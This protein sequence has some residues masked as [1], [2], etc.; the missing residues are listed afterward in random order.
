MAEEEKLGDTIVAQIAKTVKFSTDKAI[1]DRVNRVGQKIAAIANTVQVPAGFGNDHVYPFKWTFN[2]IE[3]PDIN[4]FSIEGGHIYIYTGLMRLIGSDDELAGILGHEITHAAHHHMDA[5]AHEASKMD[6]K[7]AIAMIAAAFAHANTNDLGNV[8]MGAD[9]AE[10]AVLKN[11]YGEDAERDADYCG[12]IYMQKAGYDPVGMLTIQE[13]LLDVERQS[14]VVIEGTIF[15]DHPG[16]EERVQAVKD[17]LAALHITPTDEEIAR[18]S[19][20]ATQFIA[21][22]DASGAGMRDISFN[23]QVCATLH[24]PDGT[25]SA[26]L[27]ATLN[28]EMDD[29]LKFSEVVASGDS[30]LLRDIPW[31]TVLP[32]DASGQPTATVAQNIAHSLQVILYGRTFVPIDS[33]PRATISAGPD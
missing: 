13:K 33:T 9:L 5:E 3:D 14:P 4:A 23:K 12:L 31:L 32:A 15:Q 1:I 30:V 20:Y 21:A 2:V 7:M 29:G 17:H 22:P 10:V 28:A 18:L 8:F 11:T 25:R 26:A 27:L 16:S 19:A 24:D 6:T